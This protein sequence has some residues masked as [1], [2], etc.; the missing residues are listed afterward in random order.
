MSADSSNSTVSNSN[1]LNFKNI[2][3]FETDK[4]H[5]E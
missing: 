4:Q 2:C 3:N 1:F 5:M